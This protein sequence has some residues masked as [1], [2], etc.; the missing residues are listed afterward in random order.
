M[1][2]THTLTETHGPDV[3]IAKTEEFDVDIAQ[4][5]VDCKEISK[6][7]RDAVRRLLKNRVRGNKH[8][9]I[10]KLGKDLKH[11]DIGRFHA[12]RGVGL[13]TMSR[14]IRAALAQKYYWDL[15]IR[16]AQATLLQQIAEK[17]GWVCDALREFN[18][19]RDDYLEQIKTELQVDKWDAKERICRVMFGGGAEGLPEFFVEKLYPEMRA[20]MNN[21]FNEN[22]T[23][24]PSIAKKPNSVRSMMAQVLQTEERKVLLEMDRSLARQGRSMDVLIHD[25]GLVRKKDGETRFPD[26]VIHKVERDVLETTGYKVSLAIKLMQTSLEFDDLETDSRAYEERKNE[27]EVTGWKGYITFYLREQSCFI[28]V[29]QDIKDSVLMKTKT[30]LLNDEEA[31][32][33]PSGAAFIKQW[34]TD[35]TRLEYQKMDFLP[36]LSTPEHTYNLFHGFAVPPAQGDYSVFQ[37]VLRLI[38]N[39]NDKV[40]EYIEKWAACVIQRPYRK[41]GVCIVV[42]GKKGVGKDTYFDGIG[43]IIGKRHFLTTAKPEHEVFGR[44]NSQLSQLLFLK[45]E[46]ANFETNRDNEDMLKKLITSEFE[47]IERKGHDPIRTTSCVNMVMTTNKHIPIPMS[48]DER[49]FMMVEASEERR[50]DGEFW[51]RVQVEIR[52]PEVMAAYHHYLMNLDLTDFEPTRV[53]RTAYYHDV[54]QTFSP[55][56]ARYFQRLLEQAGEERVEPFH[57]TARNLF[58]SMRQSGTGKHDITEQRF[59]R[60]MKL[61]EGVINRERRKNGNEY[62]AD[63]VKLMEFIKSQGWWIDY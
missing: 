39:G 48:D 26:D 3:A 43:R 6:L 2:A 57:W 14:D 45:F 34:M 12:L 8:E 42:K 28:K 16:N 58:D 10:Y 4:K 22:R 32:Y 9:T 47:S 30:D 54:L 51:G 44:F 20:L 17:R 59:G 15:D 36:G 27:W 21:V 25:G 5:I 40:F 46:E 61:Y 19:H 1:S 38:A 52:K 60:D 29:S 63:P 23:V 31:H 62:T 24:Y 56:H 55:Y 53:V 37:E 11:E 41:T 7:D 13:Q 33:L 50:G 18:D 35:P 49:R